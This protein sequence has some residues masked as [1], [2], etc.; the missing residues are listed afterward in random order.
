MLS[1]PSVCSERQLCSSHQAPIEAVQAMSIKKLDSA[2]KRTARDGWC[3]RAATSE[4]GGRISLPR[5][6]ID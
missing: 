3:W 4:D 6:E 5:T 2:A 1:H